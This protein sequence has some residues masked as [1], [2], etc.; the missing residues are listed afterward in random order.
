MQD[1]TPQLAAAFEYAG[2]EDSAIADDTISRERLWV[3]REGV[4]EAIASIGVPHKLDIGVRLANLQAFMTELPVVV[5]AAAI[6]P[7]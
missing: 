3:L 5:R 7:A 4:A 6:M 1:P 2:V